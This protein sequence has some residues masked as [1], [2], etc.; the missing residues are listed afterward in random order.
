MPQ[1]VIWGLPMTKICIF[2]GPKMPKTAENVVCHQKSFRGLQWPKLAS[3]L[4]QKYKKKCLSLNV[5]ESHLGVS[6]DQTLHIL[7]TKCRKL[8]KLLCVQNATKVTTKMQILRKKMQH[9]VFVPPKKNHLGFP[10]TKFA[11]FI[12]G[13][14]LFAPYC[15]TAAYMYKIFSSS[16]T[17]FYQYGEIHGWFYSCLIQWSDHWDVRGLVASWCKVEIHPLPINAC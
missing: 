11:Y 14:K 15:N 9:F 2:L 7:E 8:Q 3:F 5:P 1:K 4:S 13:A 6:S 12:F 17:S 16:L 10:L